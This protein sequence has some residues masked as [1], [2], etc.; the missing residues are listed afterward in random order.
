M[1]LDEEYADP[2]HPMGITDEGH[3]ALSEALMEFGSDITVKKS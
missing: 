3:M 1:D 2:E